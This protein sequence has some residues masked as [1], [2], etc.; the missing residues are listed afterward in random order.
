M[1]FFP[2][3]PER[4]ADVHCFQS[5]FYTR[6]TD[7]SRV[8]EAYSYVASWTKQVGA[9][10]RV[11]VGNHVGHAVCCYFTV[12]PHPTVT[13]T[14]TALLSS[15]CPPPQV[16]IFE[17]K[18]LIV[19][20]NQS[21]HWSVLIV[22]RPHLLLKGIAEESKGGPPASGDSAD[23]SSGAQGTPGASTLENTPEEVGSQQQE[24]LQEQEQVQEQEQEQACILCLD[25]LAMHNSRTLVNRIKG[26]LVEE[27]LHKKCGGDSTCTR[28][29][30]FQKAADVLASTSI[31]MKGIPTQQNGYDC[32]MSTIKYVQAMLRKWP[33][34]TNKNLS[35]RFSG[36]F[37]GED[38]FHEDQVT[39][40]AFTSCVLGRLCVCMCV[41]MSVFSR[42]T[43]QGRHGMM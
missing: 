31:S 18:M 15:P 33:S 32:G 7:H 3:H 6:L 12:Q 4:K 5:F 20:I 27:Y 26:Y 30:Q 40:C 41:C 35:R 37:T 23:S 42:V 14:L 16:D 1:P 21:T 9:L 36:F 2:Q 38:H 22:L 29:A 13:L 8:K 10:C 28:F 24:Q 17:K 25:S 39:V 43:G 34:P 11:D 19:P